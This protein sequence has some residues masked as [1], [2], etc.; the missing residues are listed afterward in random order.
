MLHAAW[1]TPYNTPRHV[2]HNTHGAY[3]NIQN[4]KAGHWHVQVGTPYYMSPELMRNL[5]YGSASDTWALGATVGIPVRLCACPATGR[6]G[7]AFALAG[8]LMYEMLTTRHAFEAK[9]IKGLMKQVTAGACLLWLRFDTTT[10][11]SAA[12]PSVVHRDGYP[13]DGC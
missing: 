11:V 5:P 10:A 9:D 12:P 1:H 13:R 4:T 7:C 8:C 3:D 6:S 2:A